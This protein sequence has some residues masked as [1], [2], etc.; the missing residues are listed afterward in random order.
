MTISGPSRPTTR[1][2]VAL[3]VP[4]TGSLGPFSIPVN[5]VRPSPLRQVPK[6]LPL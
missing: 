5:V 1:N 4:L 3:L 2:R 6:F